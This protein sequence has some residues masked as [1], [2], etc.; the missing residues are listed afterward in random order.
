[1]ERLKRIILWDYSRETSV[2]VIF[3]LLIVAFI[4]LTPKSWFDRRERLT[5][6]ATRIILKSSDFRGSREEVEAAVR[7][8]TGNQNMAIGEIRETTAPNGE[9]VLVIDVR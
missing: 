8:I 1:M 6:S 9:K 4:F 5:S 7:Q 3:C 2:Y